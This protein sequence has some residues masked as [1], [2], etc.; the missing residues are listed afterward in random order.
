MIIERTRDLSEILR[1]L[2]FETEIRKKRRDRTRLQKMLLS[3]Q[4]QLENPLF[5]FWIAYDSEEEIAPDDRIIGYCIG[6]ISLLPGF[7]GLYL[8]RIFAQTKEVRREFERILRTWAKE[9]KIRKCVITVSK[10]IK[11]IQRMHNFK[12]IS[13]NME[14]S[15]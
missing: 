8:H 12:P 1:C 5:G 14:R 3:I 7:E 2:P 15:I 10:N 4:A 6:I 9:N 11:A 13:I